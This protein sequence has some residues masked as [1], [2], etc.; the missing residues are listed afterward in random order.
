M[1]KIPKITLAELGRYLKAGETNTYI[2]S[3]NHKA[4]T[5]Q[6]RYFI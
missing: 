1:Q 3:T 4:I 5:S 2:P 6:E